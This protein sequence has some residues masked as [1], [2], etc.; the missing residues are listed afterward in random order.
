MNL[1]FVSNEAKNS[2]SDRR[3]TIDYVKKF[4]RKFP[5]NSTPSSGFPR[6]P[7]GLALKG[8]PPVEGM[9]EWLLLLGHTVC[10]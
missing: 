6:A 8:S 5:T 3:S 9:K 10:V 7:N 1:K 2:E 4:R